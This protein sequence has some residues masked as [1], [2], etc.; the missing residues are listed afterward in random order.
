[1]KEEIKTV[2]KHYC[3]KC[4][5]ELKNGGGGFDAFI[6]LNPVVQRYCP[7]D[8]CAR[9]GVVTVASVPKEITE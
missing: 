6:F 1:M 3:G 9:Y 4:K 5:E 8:K 2:T 7:N